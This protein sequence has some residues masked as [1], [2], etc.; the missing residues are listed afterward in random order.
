[1]SRH[2]L[3]PRH[4]SFV[5]LAL[6][7]LFGV[8]ALV[9]FAC[10]GGESPTATSAPP[11]PTAT[12]APVPTLTPTSPATVIDGEGY[13]L[14]VSKGCSA[15]HGQDAQGTQIAP[16]L[17]GHSESI[18]RRQ[19]RSPIG[20]MP[21]FP[22]DKITNEELA[23]LAQFIAELP[24]GHLHTKPV[25]V[26]QDLINH[27][28]MALLS[29]EEN[30]I[31]EGTHHINHIIDLVTGDHLARMQAILQQLEAG[32][33]HE[34]THNIEGMLAGTADPTLSIG[35]MHLQMALSSIRVEDLDAAIHHVEH[36]IEVEG[37]GGADQGEV[38]LASLGAQEAHEAED[39]IQTIL[40]LSDEEHAHEEGDEHAE[41]EEHAHEEGKEHVEGDEHTEEDH[42]HEEAEE[43]A[44]GDEHSEEEHTEE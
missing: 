37:E 40:G 13:Q 41:E 44:A 14:Y 34:A 29:L 11:S 1:M 36:F 3:Q 15:C 23:L 22:P 39:I 20:L 31:E 5:A 9:A 2:K 42:A 25:D 32:D 12:T 27:H 6:I 18:V 38:I 26:G 10:G 4:K 8:T 28:W 24:G 43:H 16:A 30:E 17:P 33:L 19:V 35:D 7:L 21:V